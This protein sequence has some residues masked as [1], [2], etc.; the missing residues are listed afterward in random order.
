MPLAI[1]TTPLLT[2][3]DFMRMRN[4]INAW[5]GYDDSVP[6]LNLY[7]PVNTDFDFNAKDPAKLRPLPHSE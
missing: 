7:N 4:D 5:F 3:V 1:S 2:G 6:L